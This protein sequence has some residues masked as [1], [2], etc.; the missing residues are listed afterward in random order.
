MQLDSLLSKEAASSLLNKDGTMTTFE[1]DRKLCGDASAQTIRI[2]DLLPGDSTDPIACQLKY[3]SLD[4]RPKFEAIS[5]CWGGQ[6]PG[7]EIE[8]NGGRM[9]ITKNLSDALR[10]FRKLDTIILLWADAI[11]INQKDNDEKTCQVPLMGRIYGQARN[12]KIW[13]GEESQEED[14]KVAF[15]LIGKLYTV[16]LGFKDGKIPNIHLQYTL[17][18]LG[19]PDVFDL[20]WRSVCR[21]LKRPWF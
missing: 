17:A 7:V 6:V 16:S 21:L 4:D 9:K 3:V 12:V 19:L 15:Q 20:S 13:L 5:Y 14:C 8:C 18:T 10:A 1:Y 2:V 11:C